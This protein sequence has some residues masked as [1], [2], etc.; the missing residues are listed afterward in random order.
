MP[1]K[2]ILLLSGGLD[3]A[4]CLA[5]L[6]AAPLREIERVHCLI[7]DYGQSSAVEVTKAVRLCEAWGVGYTIETHE[8][9]ASNDTHNEIPARN[10]IFIS[11]AAQKA[12]SLG[13][14]CVAMGAEPD[15]TYTDSSVLFVQEAR[16]VLALFGL[17]LITPIKHLENKRAVLREALDLGVPLALCHSSRSLAVDGRCKT[18]T[19]FLESIRSFFPCRIPPTVLLYHLDCLRIKTHGREC[20]VYYQTS[21][22]TTVNF[23][24]AAALFTIASARFDRIPEF[25]VYTTG[26]WGVALQKAMEVAGDVRPLEVIQTNQ[27]DQLLHQQV[28]CDSQEAQWGLKQALGLL[29]RARYL[30]KV[31]CRVTQG[32]L[33]H[34]LE[35]LGYEVTLP[36]HGDSLILETAV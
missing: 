17:D 6:L 9:G 27:L 33:A 12:L 26:S 14:N 11:L 22:T 31:S 5:Q 36:G 28:N 4:V 13:Y 30:R 2:V 21:L 3:S 32:H 24:Y 25:K 20:K 15:S 18:S 19:L 8:F 29:P 16:R 34:A 1:Y 35:S 23:K 7:F 10:L